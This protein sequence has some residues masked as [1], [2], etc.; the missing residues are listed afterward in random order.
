M[1]FDREII[2]KAVKALLQDDAGFLTQDEIDSAIDVGLRQVNNDRPLRKVVDI[3]GDGT[4]SYALEPEG[5]QKQFSRILRVEHPAGEN[6]PIFLAENDDWFWDEDPTQI[7]G[8]KIR[9]RFLA[10]TPVATEDIRVTFTA[11][12]TLTT[13]TT[14]TDLSDISGNGLI[15]LTTEMLLRAMANRF[16]STTDS[17]IDADAVD[18]V[19]RSSNFSFN[20]Q[21]FKEKYRQIIGLSEDVKAAQALGEGDIRFPF[22]E[23]L[24]WHPSRTR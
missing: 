24:F 14:T 18:Y 1:A 17:T 5:F 4:Q 2:R 20:A 11:N 3:T 12:Y 19:G 21:Q 9:L 15:Y 7:A 10:I 23:D 8:E 22:N 16:A 13:D 6:P